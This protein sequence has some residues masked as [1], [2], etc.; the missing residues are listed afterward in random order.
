[1]PDLRPVMIA[2]SMP[3][4]RSSFAPW[5]SIELNAFIVSPSAVNSRPPSVSTPSTSKIISFT[6]LAR[7]AA[8]RAE[9]AI[10]SPS[11]RTGRAC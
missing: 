8:V 4:S 6:R 9:E 2:V 1:M 11:S 7:S 5:P 10:R 3:A